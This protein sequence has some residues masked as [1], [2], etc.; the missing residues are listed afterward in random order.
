MIAKFYG[1]DVTMG[2]DD[3]SMSD[4][5]PPLGDCDFENGFCSY[6]QDTSEDDIDWDLGSGN[7]PG[8]RTGP[9]VDHTTNTTG[10]LSF[11]HFIF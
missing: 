1:S 4:E 9:H 2:I 6:V 10:G 11:I 3:F 7:T 8:F 5:C